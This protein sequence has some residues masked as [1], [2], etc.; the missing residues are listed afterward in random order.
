M[1]WFDHI[2]CRGTPRCD[3]GNQ[4]STVLDKP[5]PHMDRLLYG[6][7]RLMTESENG[8]RIP[9]QWLPQEHI[10]SA[11]SEIQQGDREDP[12]LTLFV[13]INTAGSQ[14][15]AE[16]LTYS[17]LKSVMP[18]CREGIED[19]SRRFMLPARMVLLLSTLTLANLASRRHDSVPPA[20]PDVNRF[21][22]LVQGADTA[23]PDFRERLRDLL[24]TGNAKLII[25]ATYR[26]L[27]I[28]PNM[29][30][31]R[32]YR[33]LPLQ[34]AR[35]AQNH[36]HAFLL[37]LIWVQSRLSRHAG[38]AYLGLDE[39]EHRRIIGLICTLGWFSA[40]DGNAVTAKRKYLLRLWNKRYALQ[41]KGILADMNEEGFDE[42]VI[43][44]IP[45]P[46]ILSSAIAQCVTGYGFGGYSTEHWQS[47]DLWKNFRYRLDDIKEAN[48][49]Y[50]GN[51][52]SRRV[53]EDKETESRVAERRQAAWE[54]FISKTIHNTEFV[55][56]AQRDKLSQW[57][58]EFDPTSPSQLQDTEQPWD[59]DHIHPQNYV[60]GRHSMPPLITAWHSTIGNLRAWPSEINRAQH[61]LVPSQKLHHPNEQEKNSYGLLSARDLMKAS[62]ISQAQ[63]WDDSYPNT[64]E[65]VPSYY[66]RNGDVEKHKQWQPNRQALI[67][68]ITFRYV[69]LYSRWHQELRISQLF[70]AA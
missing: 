10:D 31:E 19:L 1:D 48:R 26:L 29:R 40:G 41:E 24:I 43:I 47:W 55:L 17:I 65:W 42:D 14:P 45:P 34:A 5:T 69:D 22:R 63:D 16:E 64:Y 9:A 18:E 49:W 35:I 39:E 38:D 28:N 12:V 46:R 7:R 59:I 25:E 20:F 53:G 13:R 6:L 52:K 27:V 61:D 3:L 58:P 11:P 60:Q 33:L 56:Y 37:L 70:N 36:E 44:P 67:R 62:A 2:S 66:L 54:Q 68:A 32:P 51:V 21:R 30:S 8:L 57:Y 15:S 50:R 23:M 4:L